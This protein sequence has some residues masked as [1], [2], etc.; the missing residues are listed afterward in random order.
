MFVCSV[1]LQTFFDHY[2]LFLTAMYYLW[3][4]YTTLDGYIL[5][6]AAIYAFRRLYVIFNGYILLLALLDLI[7]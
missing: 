3:R 7:L 6:T 4:S 2:K 5:L 1:W